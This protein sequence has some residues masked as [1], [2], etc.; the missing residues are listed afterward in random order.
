MDRF[1]GSEKV[2]T[3]K[4]PEGDMI[5]LIIFAVS[6]AATGVM[7]AWAMDFKSRRELIQGAV[8]GLV[9]GVVMGLMIG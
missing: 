2:E 4:Y 9:V 6:G 8:G 7:T 1:H 5:G 3:S